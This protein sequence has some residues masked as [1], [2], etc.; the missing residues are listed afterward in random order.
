M[1]EMVYSFVFASLVLALAKKI[2]IL[3]V[4]KVDSIPTIATTI[5][6]STRL[7]PSEFLVELRL[8]LFYVPNTIF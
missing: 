2:L 5:I 6:S 1:V 4:A 3:G 8:I 7:N